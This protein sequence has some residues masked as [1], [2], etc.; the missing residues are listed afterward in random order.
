MRMRWDSISQSYLSW[1]LIG[2]FLAQW[3]PCYTDAAV[4]GRHIFDNY[5]KFRNFCDGFI[6]AKV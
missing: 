1:I 2:C 3:M 5:G 4:Q 6:F